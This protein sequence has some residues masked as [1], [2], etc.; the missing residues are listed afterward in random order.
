MERWGDVED[1][2]GDGGAMKIMGISRISTR[3]ARHETKE[4]KRR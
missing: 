4:N 3:G 1:R 2:G